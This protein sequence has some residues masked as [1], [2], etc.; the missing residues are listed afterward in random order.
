MRICTSSTTSYTVLTLQHSVWT[1]ILIVYQWLSN[2]KT[3]SSIPWVQSVHHS[4]K[5]NCKQHCLIKSVSSKH[6]VLPLPVLVYLW[7]V[8][9]TGVIREFFGL[10]GPDGLLGR[11]HDNLTWARSE[12]KLIRDSDTDTDSD[13]DNDI[14][15]KQVKLIFQNLFVFVFVVLFFVLFCF[16]FCFTFSFTIL[17]LVCF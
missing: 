14:S 12:D 2:S 8:Y 4:I 9:H 17:L 11:C 5:Y 13:T 16:L 15:D 6:L 7:L 10:Y 3:S 1:V